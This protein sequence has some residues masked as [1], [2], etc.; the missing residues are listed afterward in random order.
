M[1]T[2]RKVGIT[3]T[4]PVEVLLAGGATPVDL[5]NLFITHPDPLSL[6]ER[7]EEVG[8]PITSCGWIKG[9]YTT[10]LEGGIQELVAVT[11]GDCSNTHALMETLEIK[12]VKVIPF[13]YP[14]DRDPDL[15]RLQIKK[16][17][18]YFNVGWPQVRGIKK[19]LDALR[20]KIRLIDELTWQEG[21]V[22]GRENHYFQV[23]CSDFEGDTRAFEKKVDDFLA[24]VQQRPSA[25]DYIPLGFVGV[26][27]I[28][29]SIYDY[30]ET[31]GA[32][33]V[34]NEV[35]RQFAMP[36]GE[37]NLVEQYR[38]YTYPY[39]IF[40]R[41]ED[42]AAETSKRSLVGLI[43]YVQAFCFRQIEDIVLRQRLSVPVLTLEGDKPTPLDAQRKLR[44]E[45]F[46]EMIRRKKGK[47]K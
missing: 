33:V 21:K 10:A 16:L 46:V 24:Q 15:L 30:L 11:Q 44:L 43:H 1:A 2:L 6:V 42:I 36:Y 32:R 22:R 31:L 4:I 19:Q 47:K 17:G 37:R 39:G 25:G 29:P 23:S 12:G 7:A 18:Q 40:G 34:Y 45:S 13:A 26:P 8:F 9:L 38:R 5:N 35:Q 3:T 14:Y 20:A 41:L 28:F 27:P